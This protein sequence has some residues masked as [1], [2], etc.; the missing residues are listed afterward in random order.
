[1]GFFTVVALI[2]IAAKAFGFL[3]ISWLWCFAPVLIDAAIGTFILGVGMF[4]TKKV[5]KDFN[6]SELRFGLPTRRK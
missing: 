6:Y 5:C 4:A 1:M 3:G 2:L